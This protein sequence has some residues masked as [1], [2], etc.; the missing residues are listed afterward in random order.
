MEYRQ[1]GVSGLRVSP[2]CPRAMMF[3]GATDKATVARAH[4]RGVNLTDTADG[5]PSYPLE[6]RM[7]RCL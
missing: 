3:G 7:P 2:L 1:P 4:E 6:G 5:D